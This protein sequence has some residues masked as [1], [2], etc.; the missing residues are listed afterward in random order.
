MNLKIEILCLPSSS[1]SLAIL[2]KGTCGLAE[3]SDLIVYLQLLTL[4]GDHAINVVNQ[5]ISNLPI[6]SSCFLSFIMIPW[7]SENTQ[8]HV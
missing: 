1:D 3:H 2:A 6:Q 8:L 7:G 5:S 4:C